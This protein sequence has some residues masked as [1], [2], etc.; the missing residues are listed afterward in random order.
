[1]KIDIP[2]LTQYKNFSVTKSI[3]AANERINYLKKILKIGSNK[4][5]LLVAKNNPQLI[6]DNIG[7]LYNYLP[8]RSIGINPTP[9]CNRRCRF[10]SSAQRNRINIEDGIEINKINLR[11][12]LKEFSNM[13][14]Q[15]CVLV[16]GGEALLAC[17]GK[18]NDI[19]SDF[20]LRYGFNTNG[21]KLD[22]FQ[23]PRLLRKITWIS[24]SIIAHN[25]K[26]YNKVAGLSKKNNQFDVLYK[27]LKEYLKLT[28][29]L[30]NKEGRAPYL[31]AKILICK[32]NYFFAGKIYNFIK[33][34]G[35]KDI[36][37][38]CVNNFELR[39]GYRGRTLTPQDV[40]LSF[41]QREKLKQILSQQTD[42]SE[43]EIK[44]I[45]EKK[46]INEK[47]LDS[48]AFCWNILLGLIANI[49]TDG[50]VYLCNPRLG[51]G[52]F[53]IGNIKLNSFSDI[54]KSKKHREVVQKTCL[55][56][57]Q[58]CD[59]SKCRHFRVNQMIEQFLLGNIE[60]EDR[61]Y[62]EKRMSFFP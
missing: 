53:S 46:K 5:L 39:E 49:D 15:G 34:F 55:S 18:I 58:M 62:Y 61:N 60:L 45:V 38:R 50:E 59:L 8:P 14:G 27:N 52:D 32:E 42:L 25:K 29:D 17:N 30:E 24:L 4:E 12:L 9:I 48:P 44:N 54:W 28:D 36:A 3:D 51:I 21:V 19:I 16:G 35:F 31:S 13:K 40:E 41:S 11:E 1:M 57:H 23:H 33:T 10:C 47:T 7:T 56:F 22:K 37:L 26:L 6:L 2:D 20:P 43:N